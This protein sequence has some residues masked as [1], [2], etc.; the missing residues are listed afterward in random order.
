MPELAWEEILSRVFRELPGLVRAQRGVEPRRNGTWRDALP[1][2]FCLSLRKAHRQASG[3]ALRPRGHNISRYSHSR[4]KWEQF[5]RTSTNGCPTVSTVYLE[6]PDSRS[7]G[8]FVTAAEVYDVIHSSHIHCCWEVTHDGELQPCMKPA[9][10]IR[11]DENNGGLGEVCK[12]HAKRI[13]V[14]LAFIAEVAAGSK[15]QGA[16]T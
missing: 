9:V 14:P 13:L 12:Y 5:G 16:D 3:M 2:L 10:A 7:G 4:P 11:F 15:P 1:H 6:I 8:V